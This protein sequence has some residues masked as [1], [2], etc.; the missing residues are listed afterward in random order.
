MLN[1]IAIIRDI[2]RFREADEL[3]S[4]F[5]SVVSHELK[6]PVALIKG[7][8]S[9]LRREDAAWDKDVIRDSLEIIEEEADR[10]TTMIDNLL[11]ASRLE[12]GGLR[13]NITDVNLPVLVARQ[14]ERFRAQTGNARIETSF[15]DDFP[16][17]LAD[18]DRVAQVI[19]NLISNA[20]KYGPETGVIRITGRFRRDEVILCV[21]D[22]GPGIPSAE[23]DAVF[24][25][26]YRTA[27]TRAQ[28]TQGYGVGL[29]LIAHVAA[30]HGGAAR[31][32][33]VPS[34]SHLEV[35]L[36]RW[37]AAA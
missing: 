28:G 4:T 2:T 26:F 24:A 30:I 1:I 36:P 34:G 13:L 29:A 8:T 15:S 6:T 18:E 33:D 35:R 20:L 17:V 23:R 12:I 14:I 37:T 11:D 25:P 9:T 10:L 19:S 27:E 16:V 32:L 5:I 7:Y 31:F 3:K 21:Q 22:E